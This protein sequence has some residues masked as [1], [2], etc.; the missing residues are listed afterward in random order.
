M[1]QLYKAR[2]FGALFQDTFAFLKNNG[3]HLYKN[4]FIVNGIFIMILLVFGYFFS[5]FYTDFIFGGLLNNSTTDLDNYLN[6][7]AGIFFILIIL[8]IIVGLTAAVISYSFVPIY[9][10]LYDRH[11][12]KNFGVNEII[13]EF[14]KNVFSI[15]I[16]LICGLI[17]AIPTLLVAGITS[18]IL[19]IT[20]I[21]IFALPLV[22]GA[23][24]LFYQLT[25]MEKINSRKGIWE[26]FG[27]SLSLL[28]QN[29]WVSIGCVGIFY[30]MSYL[31]QYIVSLVPYV[32]GMI[33]MFT[34]IETNTQPS[35]EEFSSTMS[36]TMILVFILSSLVS[37][38][39]GV[40][41]QLNQGIVFY[42]L[43][44]NNE[45]I[46]TKSIIDQI[47]SGE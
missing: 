30:V 28:G 41:T 21:G 45:N 4:F 13:S 2:D 35:P 12:G 31:V 16:F 8:F 9:L 6:E 19:T 15:F 44:E 27:Y 32:F 24:S 17:L 38:I 46:N 18:L 22:L 40:I 10:K 1:Q 11:E 23:V 42:S 43:K 33:S 34:T 36:V 26:S 7:N 20:L 3:G 25:L 29:F 37:A 14:R 5:K 47:G 39:L